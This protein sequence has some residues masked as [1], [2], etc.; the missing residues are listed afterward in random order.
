MLSSREE[1]QENFPS[2][3][4]YSISDYGK[5]CLVNWE[6]TIRQYAGELMELAGLIAD[7]NAANK[8]GKE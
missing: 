5:E 4:L 1:E 2:K 8:T 7:V 3:R 6:N